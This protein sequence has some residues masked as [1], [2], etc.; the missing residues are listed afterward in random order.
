MEN[1]KTAQ[2]VVRAITDRNYM[3]IVENLNS[4]VTHNAIGAHSP[5]DHIFKD[6]GQYVV[7]V[8]QKGTYK[9]SLCLNLTSSD[10]DVIDTVSIN[11]LSLVAKFSKH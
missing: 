9:G 1:V 2:E 3:V 8:Y 11:L 7:R 5:I 10:N 4:D 6:G